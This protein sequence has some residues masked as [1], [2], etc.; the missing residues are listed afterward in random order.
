MRS[1]PYLLAVRATGPDLTVECIPDSVGGGAL[2][3][4]LLGTVDSRNVP[5]HHSGFT[6]SFAQ[7]CRPTCR[8][9][10]RG[11]RSAFGVATALV[12]APLATELESL[13]GS[14]TNIH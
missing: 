12:R 10:G 1:V 7:R 14:E 11:A 2:P 9:S 3:F 6:V 4:A 5:V 8:F 13:G